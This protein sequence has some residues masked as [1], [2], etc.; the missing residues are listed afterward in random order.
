MFTKGRG[1]EDS[2]PA[3]QQTHQSPKHKSNP[4][5]NNKLD[6]HVKLNSFAYRNNWTNDLELH[7]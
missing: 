1:R 6:L 4:K 5:Q 3:N 2:E 7:V